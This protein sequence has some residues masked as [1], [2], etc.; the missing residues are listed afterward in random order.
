MQ[1]REGTE[2]RINFTVMPSH[3]CQCHASSLGRFDVQVQTNTLDGAHEGEDRWYTNG[4]NRQRIVDEKK[5]TEYSLK[6]GPK[7]VKV[8]TA[9]RKLPI[10]HFNPWC[11]LAGLKGQKGIPAGN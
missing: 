1:I 7:K 6:K 2:K 10:T 4:R 9:S 3:T 8:K 5:G 11:P